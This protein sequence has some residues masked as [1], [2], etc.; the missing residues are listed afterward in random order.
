MI[1]LLFSKLN[2]EMS[3]TYRIFAT[4]IIFKQ[5]F[6]ESFLIHPLIAFNNEHTVYISRN[7]SLEDAIH[8][9]TTLPDQ[10]QH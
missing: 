9:A 7:L 10:G 2:I 5:D 8:I 1:L 6:I 4:K 3:Y